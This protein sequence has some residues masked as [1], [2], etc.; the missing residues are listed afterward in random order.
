MDK[1][2][3]EV[4]G[5]NKSFDKKILNDI[6]I[7]VNHGEIV[8]FIGPNGAGKSTTLKCITNLIYPDSGEIYIDGYNL[9]K[10]RKNALMSQSSLIEEPGLNQNMT[11]RDNLKIYSAL[12][13]ISKDRIDKIIE[14]IGIGN[15]IDKNV[16]SYSLGMKQRLGIGMAILPIPKLLILDEPTNGLDPTYIINLREILKKMVEAEGV[17]ILFSSHQLSEV[18]KIADRIVCINKGE[19]IATPDNL[20]KE[21]VYKINLSDMNKGKRL[22]EGKENYKLDDN[23]LIS[24]RIDEGDNL[25]NYLELFIN[26]DIEIIDVFKDNMDIED[27]YKQIYFK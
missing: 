22:L 18:E 25:N 27:I 12:R 2:A 21:Y 15:H 24:L 5:L 7:K 1:Y 4:I 13:G 17:S 23:G 26:N 3:L 16:S 14:F 8:G 6:N 11:G 9:K 10:D 20:F 19:I